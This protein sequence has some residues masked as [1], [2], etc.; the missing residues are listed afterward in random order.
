LL[1]AIFFGAAPPSFILKLFSEIVWPRSVPA[2]GGLRTTL[3]RCSQ[4]WAHEGSNNPSSIMSKA[5]ILRS[6]TFQSERATLFAATIIV[7]SK[8]HRASWAIDR[9]SKQRRSSQVA[10]ASLRT[11]K[12]SQTTTAS[13]FQVIV[14]H[15]RDC[16]FWRHALLRTTTKD[17]EWSR[18]RSRVA[19]LSD[20]KVKN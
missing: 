16:F 8:A 11:R 18:K 9:T 14:G 7:L 15:S 12:I 6:A 20:P 4:V 10:A 1:P 5:Q 17:V 2:S 3:R 13:A 19:G